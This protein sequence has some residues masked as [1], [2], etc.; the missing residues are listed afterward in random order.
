MVLRCLALLLMVSSAWGEEGFRI[1]KVVPEESVGITRFEIAP[2]KD[3]KPEVIFVA[4]DPI[5][6]SEDVESAWVD[7]VSPGIISFKLRDGGEKKIGAATADPVGNLRLAV[8]VDGRVL[9][10]PV[11]R[12]T[13]GRNFQ[14][15]GLEDL[16]E[17]EL[18]SYAL[19]I[20]GKSA[21]EVKAGVEEM[22]KQREALA[23]M[24]RVEP[25]YYTDDE[26]ALLKA[27]REKV[28]IHFLDEVPTK[29]SLDKN[30]RKGM[31]EA[32]VIGIFHK[33]RWHKKG[34]DGE[35]IYYRYE[36][37]DEKRPREKRMRME[38]FEVH[39]T[40]GKVTRWNPLGWSDNLP[41]PK[42]KNERM[43]AK[44]AKRLLEPAHDPSDP[45]LDYVKFLEETKVVGEPRDLPLAETAQVMGLLYMVSQYP[46][47]EDQ[48]IN[49]DCDV[50]LA[51]SADFPEIRKLRKQANDSGVPLK[52]LH[53]VLKPYAEGE[54]PYPE[55]L[56][57]KK[58]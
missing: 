6:T 43:G 58:D 19:M 36:L 20:E 26:Y 52:D 16:T 48:T 38:S 41:E 32:E 39:F 29:E 35:T 53:L 12:A 21:D 14:V 50:M 34:E 24:P 40:D 49:R 45:E 31:T 25:E 54:M 56:L 28:G 44:R 46:V 18:G 30:L 9:M 51:L 10:A 37:A 57:K 55:S 47:P 42:R 11:V 7:P 1:S 27:A 2:K 23:K 5:V 22:R 8:L 4:N 17:D 13:L 3:Q 15:S 33:P